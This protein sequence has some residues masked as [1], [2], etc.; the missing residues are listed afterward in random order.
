MRLK[1]TCIG[2]LV[3]LLLTGCWTSGPVTDGA[4]GWVKPVYIS[5]NDV[6]TDET[7]R[8]ILVH[9]ETWEATCGD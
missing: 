2:F 3:L 8:Q 1:E 7:A 4:C 5:R 6:L 9:N